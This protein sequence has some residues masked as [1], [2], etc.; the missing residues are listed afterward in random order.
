MGRHHQAVDRGTRSAAPRHQLGD[1]DGEACALATIALGRQGVGDHDTAIV[2]CR[3]AGALGRASLGSQE[4]TLAR[5]PTVLATSLHA[6]GRVNEA[7][8][9]RQEADSLN[10]TPR[11][12]RDPRD[13]RVVISQRAGVVTDRPAYSA[14]SASGANASLVR[15]CAL[16][17]PAR[18]P[19][20]GW[21][22][23]C[24]ARW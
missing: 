7:V 23:G 20:P 13:H 14:R 10:T 21:H 6:L 1:T 11:A 3:R 8:D 24:A 22:A 16:S 9:C 17:A 2:H 5:P 4:E 19:T 12:G 15:L 18:P